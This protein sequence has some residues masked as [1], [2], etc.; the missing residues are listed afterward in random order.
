V[1]EAKSSAPVDLAA[2]ART[3]AADRFTAEIVGAFERAGVASILLKGPS[4]ARWLY[5]G[6]TRSYR[7][8]DLLVSPSDLDRAESVLAERGFIHLPLSDIPHDRPW[9]SH[10]WG[11]LEDGA[12]VDLHRTLIGVGVEPEKLWAALSA[13][14]EPMTVATVDVRVLRL[15]ARAMH[16]A[17]HAA[18]DGPKATKSIVDLKQAVVRVPMDI[19]VEATAVARRCEAVPAFASGLRLLPEGARLAA[20]LSLPE[21]APVEVALR[22]RG[23][24]G[25]L[26]VDWVVS[27]PGLGGKLRTARSKLFPPVAFMKVWSPLANK[28]PAGLGLSYLYR[29]GWLLRRTVPALRD[30]T[31]A[32]KQA[33]RGRPG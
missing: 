31:R 5:D 9:H 33:R 22:A 11:R 24:R 4:L 23:E 19:W 15:P 13:D 21:H 30:W 10:E 20:E 32:R 27:A 6:N 3:L 8:T 12:S 17:L 18:Q 14:V 29:I 25:A 26:A 16:V 7:D 28:G 2:V 1:S